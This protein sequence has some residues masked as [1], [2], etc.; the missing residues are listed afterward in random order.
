MKHL[1]A[2]LFVVFA[3]T[4]S[5]DQ[6][7]LLTTSLKDKLS[8][9]EATQA[10]IAAGDKRALICKFC[11]GPDGNSKKSSIPN[12]AA[13]NP[14]YVIRQLELFS[15]GARQN[16]TMNEI[17]KV[18]SIKDMVD[19]ALFYSSLSVNA[20]TSYNTDLVDDGRKLFEAKCFFCHGKDAH[21]KEELPRIASQPEDYVIKT[22]SSYTSTLNKR[23]ETEMSKI[24]RTLKEN[25]ILALAAY[26]ASLQ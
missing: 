17:V 7:Q 18:L 19:I 10:A 4:S 1:I 22:L 6:L 8:S 3:Q 11:H 23:A 25:E 15:S 14:T 21:G 12:L 26:L 24:A 2:L 13:Q 20:Q 16:K 9:P 5:A